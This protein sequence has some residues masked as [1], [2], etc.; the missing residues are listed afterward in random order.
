VSIAGLGLVIAFLAGIVSFASPCV[1]PLVPAYVGYMVGTS[2]DGGATP[3]RIALYQAL[4]FVAGFSLVF[5]LLWASVGVVGYVLQDQIGVLR[6]IG[7][8]IL[9][10]FGL[11]MAGII[12]FSAFYREARL[13]VGPMSGASFGFGQPAAAPSFGRSA[14]LGI[15][16]AAGWTPCIGPMLGGILG[17]AM[18]SSTVAEG[19]VLLI[20]YAAG[21]A[22]P[23]I[24]VALGA[25]AVSHRLGWFRRHQRAVDLVAGAMLVAVGFLMITNSFAKLSGLLPAFGL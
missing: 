1:L 5:I 21:L 9:V 12:N 22:V 17:L 23:F 11:N 4:A 16:F 20:A 2:P 6:T 19:T 3:R 18:V 14:L 8:A 25:T 13:P 7:G 24:L 10:F 15:V